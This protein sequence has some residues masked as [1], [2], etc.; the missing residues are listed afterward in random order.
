MK[1]FVVL[2]LMV[3]VFVNIS[4][5]QTQSADTVVYDIVDSDAEFPKE[6]GTIHQW[7]GE[8]FEFIEKPKKSDNS[9]VYI[10]FH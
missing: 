8:N 9:L 4:F 2:F 5:S 10:K 1:V 6:F 3:I 7:I